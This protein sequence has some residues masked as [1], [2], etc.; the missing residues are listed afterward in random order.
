MT[1][2]P[3]LYTTPTLIGKPHLGCPFHSTPVPSVVGCALDSSF[4]L[5]A[6]PFVVWPHVPPLPL[7]T[8]PFLLSKEDTLC[9]CVLPFY[10]WNTLLSPSPAFLS[11]FLSYY[12][13]LL[14]LSTPQIYFGA[15]FPSSLLYLCSC[16]FGPGT[17]T[18]CNS[19]ILVLSF[20][21]ILPLMKRGHTFV[22]AS[23]SLVNCI[24]AKT[25]CYVSAKVQ[26]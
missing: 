12:T 18:L 25:W 2:P 22:W 9:T 11:S 13:T 17:W 6:A 21:P 1:L 8:T 7:L 3:P 14:Y 26:R 24:V 19:N 20:L 10:T 23:H 15:Q 4:I 5:F 16:N